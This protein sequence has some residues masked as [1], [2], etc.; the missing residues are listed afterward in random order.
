MSTAAGPLVIQPVGNTSSISFD[1]MGR[2]ALALDDRVLSPYAVE[3]VLLD[4]RTTWGREEAEIRALNER[5]VGRRSMFERLAL[6][7]E[8]KVERLRG[9]PSGSGGTG[10]AEVDKEKGKGA[11][12]TEKAEEERVAEEE[13]KMEEDEGSEGGDGGAE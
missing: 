5:V 6:E 2:F 8:R 13:E 10:E 4:L 3:D 9:G 11:I 1:A 12:E 7:L